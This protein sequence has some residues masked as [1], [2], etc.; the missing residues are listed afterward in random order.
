MLPSPVAAQTRESAMATG[1]FMGKELPGY[2]LVTR[3]VTDAFKAE[4]IDIEYQFLPRARAYYVVKTGQLDASVGWYKND[5]REQGKYCSASQCLWK[6]EC[7]SI[8]RTAPRLE[9]PADLKGQKPRRNH[10]LH[11]RRGVQPGRAG[12]ARQVQRT[13][14]DELNLRKLLA[15]RIDAA[16]I[17]QAGRR[18]A[19]KPILGRRGRTSHLAS[20]RN[21][22]RPAVCHLPQTK[23]ES[24]ARADRHSIAAGP[25]EAQTTP[26]R[27]PEGIGKGKSPSPLRTR[28]GCRSSRPESCN[29]A[30][31]EH[32]RTIANYPHRAVTPAGAGTGHGRAAGI[33]QGGHAEQALQSAMDETEFEDVLI[34]G[35]DKQVSLLVRSSRLTCAPKP[36][37]ANKAC[38]YTDTLGGLGYRK[39]CGLGC[40]VVEV[41]FIG[42]MPLQFMVRAALVSAIYPDR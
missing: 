31:R 16:L 37:L 15:G 39:Q 28:H 9:K 33:P 13:S 32:H 36:V 35:Y 7:C 26:C 42:V 23:P 14:S 34:I 3:I 21:Q 1:P 40:G 17:S 5:E 12:Q 19:E 18:I 30:G 38:R 41:G 10:G 20:P 27:N 6:T 29:G 22:Q 11:L 24:E 8:S 2:G 4:G 25:V